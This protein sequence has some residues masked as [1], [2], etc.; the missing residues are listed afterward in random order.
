VEEALN[1]CLKKKKKE[2][3]K[4]RDKVLSE[5]G[6]IIIPTLGNQKKPSLNQA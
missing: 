3:K 2:R 5:C 4:E 6:F 1:E